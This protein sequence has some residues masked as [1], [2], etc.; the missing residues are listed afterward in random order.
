M[1]LRLPGLLDTVGY[2]DFLDTNDTVDFILPPNAGKK[3]K[4]QVN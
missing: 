3:H 4:E 2:V 1:T